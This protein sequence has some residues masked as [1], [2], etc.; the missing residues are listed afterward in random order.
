MRAADHQRYEAC[1]TQQQEDGKAAASSIELQLGN[2]E[3][4]QARFGSTVL[5]K[6]Q[7]LNHNLFL[8]LQSNM[9]GIL[10][11]FL[12]ALKLTAAAC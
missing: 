9:L 3:S 12:S 11:P 2:Q 4:R 1:A 8:S 5:L 10:L 7:E 6:L